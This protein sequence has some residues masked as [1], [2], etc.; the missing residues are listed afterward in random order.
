MGGW[1]YVSMQGWIDGWMDGWMGGWMGAKLD[2]IREIVPSRLADK[3]R[4]IE[5]LHVNLSVNLF[6]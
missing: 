1:M 2:T 3:V 5:C 4:K 6:L